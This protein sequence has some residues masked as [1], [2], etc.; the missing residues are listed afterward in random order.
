MTVTATLN[1]DCLSRPGD[2]KV[3]TVSVGAASDTATEGTDYDDG[4]G[5]HADDPRRR[6]DRDRDVHAGADGRRRVPRETRTLSV[7]GSTTAA[8]MAG[9]VLTVTPTELTVTVDDAAPPPRES[10]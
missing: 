4:G 9:T 3:V 1:E 10:R 2:P 8:T 7:S 5:L 6:D